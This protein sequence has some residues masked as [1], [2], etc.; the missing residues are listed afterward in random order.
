ME[1]NNGL[2]VVE[3][4]LARLAILEDVGT[5]D[6]TAHVVAESSR[7]VAVI[8]ARQEGVLSGLGVAMEVFRAIDSSIDLEPLLDPGSRFVPGTPVLRARGP[9][10]SLLTAERSALN[11]LQ[12][13]SGV[14]TMT[15]RFVELVAAAGSGTRITDTRK[16]IPGLRLLE[17]EAVLHGGGVNHR[18]GLYD[19]VMIK[20]NHIDM[21][22]GITQAVEAV[23]AAMPHVPIIVE[24]RCLA[25]AEEAARLAVGRILL[26]NMTPEEVVR[27]VGVIR[28]IASRFSPFSEEEAATRWI[29]DTWRTGDSLVQIEVSGRITL[30]NAPQYAID[31][32]DFLA[33]GQITHSAPACDL[34]MDLRV[35]P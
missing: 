21:A 2:Q 7:A 16:T 34:N 22:G 17:K 23:R 15:A 33:V 29:G 4:A 6:L 3:E 18:L 19:A 28:G 24:A 30:A 10:R 32:V 1:E 12:H 20:D 27:C 9:T 31:G 14:A 35:A 8:H 11:F 25:E 13:L 26:D 5:E